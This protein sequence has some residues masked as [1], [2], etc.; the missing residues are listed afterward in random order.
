[1]MPMIVDDIEYSNRPKII[2]I[3]LIQAMNPTKA[4]KKNN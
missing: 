2:P 4:K 1:M 3:Y